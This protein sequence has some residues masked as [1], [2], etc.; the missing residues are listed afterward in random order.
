MLSCNRWHLFCHLAV[1]FV[2]ALPATIYRHSFIRNGQ[3]SWWYYSQSDSC[4]A[5]AAQSVSQRLGSSIETA[6]WP[7]ATISTPYLY[8]H[9][10]S[11]KPSSHN[12]SDVEALLS[13]SVYFHWRM[14][15]IYTLAFI[16]IFY[17]FLARVT[18]SQII[19]FAAAIPIAINRSYAF[20]DSQIRPEILSLVWLFAAGLIAVT[21]FQ[22]RYRSYDSLILGVCFG[23]AVLSK[24]Q[25]IP[26]MPFILLLFFLHRF[27]LWRVPNYY[28]N[29]SAPSIYLCVVLSLC[30][31]IGFLKTTLIAGATYG[32]PG[33]A[34]T[35]AKASFIVT[36]ILI[37]TGG[38]LAHWGNPLI[39]N[40]GRNAVYFTGGSAISL[41]ITTLPHLLYGGIRIFLSAV[42]TT[43]FGMASFG[44]YGLGL[45]NSSGWGFSK[46][47]YDKLEAFDSFQKTSFIVGIGTHSLALVSLVT[48]SLLILFLIL[49]SLINSRENLGGCTRESGGKQT[50]QPHSW[51]WLAGGSVLC[52]LTALIFDFSMTNRTVNGSIYYFYHIYTIPFY[53]LAF[54][55]GLS[56]VIKKT[57]GSFLT[58]LNSPLCLIVFMLPVSYTA[59]R[60]AGGS[61]MV[62]GWETPE[63]PVAEYMRNLEII[64]GVSPNF[65]T[66][67]H[68]TF[69]DLKSDLLRKHGSG[70]R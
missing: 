24:I 46:S 20:Q 27:N 39:G 35:A 60:I 41:F 57:C 30:A 34:N 22:S 51:E 6:V 48:I 38:L 36:I 50:F 67:T 3:R 49:I 70:A 44:Y 43:L 40:I 25:V 7:G 65:F 18:K 55:L 59:L 17:L 37:I 32:L 5:C 63:N 14:S 9:L 11:G 53:M 21:Q 8:Y 52:L 47:L 58:T 26:A 62:K 19:A 64:E 23:F 28:G 33:Y 66:L 45:P 54:A 42:N 29:N 12:V 69:N 10:L 31:S 4:Q 61:D 16:W 2:L 68:S 1:L 13:E 56:A 15:H